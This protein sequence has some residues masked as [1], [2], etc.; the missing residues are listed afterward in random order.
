MKRILIL[1][2]ILFAQFVKANPVNEEVLSVFSYLFPTATE[3][4]WTETESGYN[5]C[6]KCSDIIGN[7]DFDKEGKVVKGL[8]YYK[9]NSLNPYILLSLRSQYPSQKI[10]GITELITPDNL[11]YTII[12][13]SE[14][15]RYI[16]ES[17]AEGHL[18]L[19]NKY[20]KNR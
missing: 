6:F 1:C 4:K 10:V 7:Y 20:K 2:A 19:Q 14:N 5:V 13:E 18:T 16:V 17:D 9:G 11:N 12:L 8:R 3:V 15:K